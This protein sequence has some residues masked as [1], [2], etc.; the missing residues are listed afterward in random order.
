MINKTTNNFIN[1][2]PVLVGL[3]AGLF[4]FT[5]N[6][7]GFDFKFFPGD[8]GDG[9]FNLYLLEHAYKFFT[10]EISNFWDAPFMY[11]ESNVISFSDNLLG[12]AP[13]YSLFRLL[14]FDVYLSYQLWFVTVS[15]LNYL[16]AYYFLKY[17][18][19]NNYA[20]VLG[21]FIFAFSL[22]LQSQLT[23]SQTFPRFAIPLALLMA[24]K[25]SEELK[26]KYF[27]Y[28]LIFVVYQIYC[29][30][31]LGFMLTIPVTILLIL[32]VIK[33]VIEGGNKIFNGKWLMQ[34]AGS[35]FISLLV[36]LPLMLP[37][38]ERKISS[39]YSHYQQ[40]L[41]TIPTIK[42]HFYSQ[43][44]SIFWDFLSKTA[45]DYKAFWDHQIFAGGIATISLIAGVLWL[46][47]KLYKNKFNIKSLPV[48]GLLFLT[49]VITFILFIRFRGI[50]AYV[51]IY[52]IPGF[53]SLRAITRIINV[54]LI[55]FAL[56]VAFAVSQ[57]YKYKIKYG[58]LLFVLILALVV[59]DNYF[60]RGKSYRTEVGQAKKRTK[61]ID[62]IFSK[63]P[64]G[65]I[66]SYEPLNMDALPAYF[67]LDA[68]LEAQKFG[69]KTLNAYTA[70]SPFDYEMYWNKP[71]EKSRNFWL[72]SKK[73]N[74]DSI[75]IVKNPETLIKLAF[76]DIQPEQLISPLRIKI[77]NMKRYIKTDK[78]WMK[79]IRK[80][81]MERNISVDSML[82][83]D[84]KWAIEN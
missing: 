67:Q 27:L 55:F 63:I 34:M 32:I 39:N 65:S 62:K 36:L 20:A 31:Y 38:T 44:G 47:V 28:T 40:I 74:Q 60:Y 83:I 41:H 2:I 49:A 11:P 57:I 79:K 21:A 45:S 13:F 51:A 9:R 6:V 16:T 71:D 18:F 73:I 54:E 4:L 58:F 33:S 5:F 8:L 14:G 46:I 1:S 78:E 61:Q 25:F 3:I 75:Y 76:K 80:K 69:L 77:D 7:T 26:P 35:L 68:M 23:H 17:V 24:V 19:K 81:A 10:G 12:S 53:S 70:T 72:R 82:E 48:T 29:G 50:S 15:V 42:S 52:F 30:I 37:Y 59:A 84:A 43:E 22:A 64:A 56:A 66:V